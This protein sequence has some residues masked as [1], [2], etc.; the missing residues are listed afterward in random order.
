MKRL[1]H[2]TSALLHTLIILAVLTLFSS[3]T[4][5]NRRISATL[6]QADSLLNID[7][8]RS[9]ELVL[10]VDSLGHISRRNEAYRDYLRT[11]ARYKAFYP[12]AG[13]TSIFS[14]TEFF[15]RRGPQGIYGKSLMIQG[16]V[17]YE[18]DRVEEALESYKQAETAL[19]GVD[20]YDDL[21]LI[22]T[23]IGE[24]YQQSYVN[25][26]EQISRYRKA[27]E[28]FEL[29][30]DRRR[31]AM[32]S[33]EYAK[34]LMKDSLSVAQI[35]TEKGISIAEEIDDTASLVLGYETLFYLEVFQD[36]DTNIIRLGKFMLDK[37]GIYLQQYDEQLLNNIYLHIAYSQLN[38]GQIKEAASTS[39]NIKLS[40]IEDKASYFLL[41]DELA[42]HN[43]DWQ[44]AYKYGMNSYKIYDSLYAA[45]YDRNLTEIERKYDILRV[46]DEYLQS[47]IKHLIITSSLLAALIVSLTVIFIIR[48]RLKEK[49]HQ[50]QE[51]LSQFN[52]MKTEMTEYS[53]KMKRQ[54][55]SNE[56][57]QK[58]V[59]ELMDVI[60]E[61]GYNYDIYS[62]RPN[63]LANKVK[64]TID[65]TLSQMN[66][67]NKARD[68][69]ENQYPGMLAE[70]FSE[71]PKLKEEDR[72]IITLMCCHF[73]TS[74]ICVMT[75]LSDV[76]LRNRKAELRKKLNAEERISIFLKNRMK[77]HKITQV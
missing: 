62:G 50:S 31:I 33:L 70:L 19:E 57:T 51:Y 7:P 73:S 35:Y 38:A 16:A 61:I 6:A 20:S 28:Y 22:N 42:Q 49:E 74:T 26:R 44:S 23:R 43:G 52:I 56:S 14:A 2:K 11:T 48:I 64:K 8:E 39:A 59:G 68:I 3:C 18:Q 5:N 36:N 72:W 40:S 58:L 27:L 65:E 54:I 63:D 9:L 76:Q 21:G 32:A 46:N 13:D 4:D 69:V 60:E 17:L 53:E 41:L 24:L 10:S 34:S 75:R 77:N 67:A 47:R 71:Y 55:H 15:R 30:G 37:F 45:N 66:F 29:S 1:P 25:D 12:V